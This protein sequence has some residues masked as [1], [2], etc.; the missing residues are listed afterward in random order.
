[1]ELEVAK[2]E[3]VKWPL[4]SADLPCPFFLFFSTDAVVGRLVLESAL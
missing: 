2:R 4:D 1:V 3:G